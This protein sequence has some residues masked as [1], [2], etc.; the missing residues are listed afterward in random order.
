[1]KAE[2]ARIEAQR[3]EAIQRY[4]QQVME[5]R[6][7]LHLEQVRRMEMFQEYQLRQQQRVLQL[8]FQVFINYCISGFSHIS[9]P[10]ID[11]SRKQ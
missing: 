7:R 8:R 5:Q 10:C 4:N 2:A 6:Q 1:M 9:P 11:E 3:L